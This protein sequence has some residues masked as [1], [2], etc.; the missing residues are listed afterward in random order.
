MTTL[1][2]MKTKLQD[3]GVNPDTFCFAPYINV[4]LDQTGE[5]YVCCASKQSIGNWKTDK[6][7][8]QYNS[9]QMQELR[10]SLYNGEKHS[11]CRSCWFAESKNS[12]STR[13]D[14]F[15]DA[16]EY[17]DDLQNFV[18]DIKQNV[19]MSST[20]NIKRMEI[21]LS[22]LC[23]LKCAHC[24]PKYSTQW[25]NT[26]TEKSNFDFFKDYDEFEDNLSHDNINKYFSTSLHSNSKHENDIKEMLSNTNLIQFAGGEPLLSPEHVSW[27]E[28]L[29]NVAK[30]SKTQTIEYNTNLMIKDIE[31]F[32][33]LWRQFKSVTLRSSIDTD[34][35]SI[36][37]FR[38]NSDKNL[39]KNN[40]K[41]IHQ[42]ENVDNIGTVTFNMTS[43]LRYK[44]IMHDWIEH[45][46]NFH[47]SIVHNHPFSCLELPTNLHRQCVADMQWCKDNVHK[48]TDNNKFVKRFKKYTD[49]CLNFITNHTPKTHMSKSTIEYIKFYDKVTDKNI[50]DF[51]PELEEYV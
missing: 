22:A 5:T 31:K 1:V 4:D 32:F 42:L 11:S 8:N 20:D 21:R 45:D 40:I 38:A 12:K 7:K 29:V 6:I 25:I 51:F 23:N 13:L 37:Y 17:I 39:L 44:N 14:S 41:K 46:L 2:E 24:S 10:S 19:D 36:E 43:A 27:L 30:T 18:G 9:S 48:Y 28:Y 47:C 26:L 49:Y 3:L 33:D 34:L 35:D 15:N 50:L 16:I